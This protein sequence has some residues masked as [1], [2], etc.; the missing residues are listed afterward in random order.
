MSEGSHRPPARAKS[1]VEVRGEHR[2]QGEEEWRRRTWSSL[3]GAPTRQRRA[4][5]SEHTHELPGTSPSPRVKSRKPRR[6][7]QGAGRGRRE[8][9]A[10]LGARVK[11]TMS[12]ARVGD[13]SPVPILPLERAADHRR[14]RGASRAARWPLSACCLP[15]SSVAGARCARSQASSPR[16]RHRHRVPSRSPRAPRASPMANRPHSE[17]RKPVVSDP[18]L[19]THLHS[20]GNA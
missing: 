8:G 9:D 7:L 1:P 13:G 17:H 6:N 11:R 5:P 15:P 18:A 2:G 19:A 3:E 12:G 14:A 16:L 20:A 10:G 4:T